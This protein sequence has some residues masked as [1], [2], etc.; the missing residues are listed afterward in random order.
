MEHL[1]MEIV[2]INLTYGN[3]FRDAIGVEKWLHPNCI[4]L[5]ISLIN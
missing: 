2:Y 3:Y 1:W 5:I 4:P